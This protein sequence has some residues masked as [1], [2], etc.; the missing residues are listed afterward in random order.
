M[1]S[2]DAKFQKMGTEPAFTRKITPAEDRQR[3]L[4]L[5]QD[6]LVDM[7]TTYGAEPVN[8]WLQ[9]HMKEE[10]NGICTA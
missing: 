1:N 9:K 10:Q 4:N 6:Q 3:F 5:T 7:V 8:K 2:A